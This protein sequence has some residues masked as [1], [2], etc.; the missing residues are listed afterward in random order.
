[1][2]KDYVSR[3]ICL[4]YLLLGGY[5]FQGHA[6]L[7]KQTIATISFIALLFVA[8]D[9]VKAYSEKFSE[10]H[11]IFKFLQKCATGLFLATFVVFI[12]GQ[13]INFDLTDEAYDVFGT[14]SLFI[15]LGLSMYVIAK[16]N[17]AQMNKK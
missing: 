9:A 15:G 11:V 4:G 14:T 7:N 8:S 2:H 6:T 10:E 5:Y 16:R 17:E 3:A 1:M 12:V 13:Y